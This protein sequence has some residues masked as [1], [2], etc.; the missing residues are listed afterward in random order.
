MSHRD[1]RETIK[2]VARN[3]VADC[4]SAAALAVALLPGH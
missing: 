1:E 3:V 2:Y 4:Q